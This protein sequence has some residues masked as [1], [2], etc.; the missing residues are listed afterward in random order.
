MQI[1]RLNRK[2]KSIFLFTVWFASP[3]VQKPNS[4]DVVLFLFNIKCFSYFS[5][6]YKGGKVSKE[7]QLK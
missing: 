1:I 6:A 4:Q 2:Q 5:L 7:E 3:P